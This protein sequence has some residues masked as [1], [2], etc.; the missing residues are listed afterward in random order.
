MLI[1]II[2]AALTGWQFAAGRMDP[3]RARQIDPVLFVLSI[4]FLI[5]TVV[6]AVIAAYIA[7]V[8]RRTRSRPAYYVQEEQT[9]SVL[10]REERRNVVD[11]TSLTEPAMS[12]PPITERPARR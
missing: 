1:A 7:S 5:V 3:A 2:L 6:L 9:S 8:A 11:S 12:K 10:L 4:Q